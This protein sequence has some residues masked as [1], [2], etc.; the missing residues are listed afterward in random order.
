MAKMPGKPTAER[1]RE[2]RGVEAFGNIQKR[3]YDKE[4]AEE[5]ERERKA[6][7]PSERVEEWQYR[8]DKYGVRPVGRIEVKVCRNA[9][10]KFAKLLTPQ[11]LAVHFNLKIARD[12]P[13]PE[14]PRKTANP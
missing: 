14:K 11:E 7:V 4:K 1:I 3:M 5:A 8:K 2:Y 10:G 13:P 9:R 12:I 6:A